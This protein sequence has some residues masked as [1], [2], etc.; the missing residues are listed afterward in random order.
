MTPQ[1]SFQILAPIK[2]ER[3]TELRQLLASM[4]SEPGRLDLHNAL[5]P[6]AQFETLHVARLLIVDDKTVGDVRIYAVPPR[7]YPLTLTLLGDVDGD[8]DSFLGEIARR[9]P[10]GLRAIF[11]H[12]EGFTS[13]T[14]L[15]EWMKAHNVP[16][17]ANYVNWQGRTVTRVRE[18]AVL[19]DAIERHIDGN[20]RAL[21]GLS[22]R[23]V[24]AKAARTGA[25]GSRRGPADIVSRAADADWVAASKS[26]PPHRL[27]VNAASV[28]ARSR[29]ACGDRR[30][31]SATARED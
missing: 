17:A 6:F 31:S 19:H 29:R 24:H 27:P 3:E 13:D 1:S 2:P 10:E 20:A 25:R 11:S 14:N 23:D 28:F 21:A 8:V 12:C 30:D 26:P 9:A 18:E 15:F 16:A 22:P 4:N 5:I 7:S